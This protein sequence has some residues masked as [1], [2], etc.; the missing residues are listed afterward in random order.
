MRILLVASG[1]LFAAACAT[2][3]TQRSTS[4]QPAGDRNAASV[5]SPPIT[6]RAAEAFAAKPLYICYNGIGNMPAT[7]DSGRVIAYSPYAQVRSVAIALAPVDG[8]LSSGYGARPG[9][10]EAFHNGVDYATGRE[11]RAV[12]AG[13][14]GVIES[15]RRLGGYGWMILI[16]HGGGVKTRYGHLSS[17]A[18]GVE[19]GALVRAGQFIGMT[20]DTGNAS[21]IHLHYELLVDGASVNPFGVAGDSYAASL[22]GPGRPPGAQDGGSAVASGGARSH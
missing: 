21:A 11:E 20:G 5:S 18:A 2:A 3:P 19:E 8:C 14:D 6:R 15:A 17:F 22:K 1:F 9:G 4:P 13:G 7:D 10:P 12:Y 16:D